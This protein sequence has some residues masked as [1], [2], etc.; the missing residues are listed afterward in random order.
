MKPF[1]MIAVVL[2]VLVA[3]AQATRFVM[4]WELVIGGMM[5]PVWAS[6]V[7]AVVIAAV[8]FMLWREHGPGQHGP[9]GHLATQVAPASIGPAQLVEFAGGGSGA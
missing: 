4:G 5:V 1:T 2:L 8:A 7:A 3:A 6:G 9:H